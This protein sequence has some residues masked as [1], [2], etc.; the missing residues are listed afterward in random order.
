MKRSVKTGVVLVVGAGV[1]G[2][3]T[4]R[5]LAIRGIE[6][7]VIE[8]RLRRP[9]AGLA[10]NLPGNAVAALRSLGAAGPVL[11][12]GLR[13][14]RREYRTSRD[15]LLFSVDE[16]AFWSAVA[17]S[18]CARHALVLD[19]LA[20]GVVVD[21]GLAALSLQREHD[22]R[23]RVMLSDG[24]DVCADLVVVADGVHSTLR[25]AVTSAAPRPSRMTKASWRFVTSN[26]GIDCWTAWS[27][28]G[29][30]F[31]LIPVSAGQVYAYASSSRGGDAGA[32]PSWLLDAYARFPEPVVQVISQALS[33]TSPPYRSPVEEVRLPTWHADA[34]VLLGDAAHATGPVWA[35]GAG[36]ALEDALV[37]ADT[38]SAGADWSVAGQA[39]EAAR[40]PRVEHVQAVT[41]RMARLVGLPSWLAHSAAPVLGPRAYH[42][43]YGPLRTPVTTPWSATPR[44]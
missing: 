13:V 42:A 29:C 7:R 6:C 35:E 11:Q 15:R 18:V 30:A 36:M 25:P 23:V 27:G 39:W 41:D 38:L 22:R 2:L 44:E 14:H 40:R 1:G 8:R 10:L 19:A 28:H 20:A 17:P 31:L 43:A 26:P 5:A 32:E 33:S 3:A 16:S 37:L 4:A 34:V 24:S 9:D 21:H 12:G